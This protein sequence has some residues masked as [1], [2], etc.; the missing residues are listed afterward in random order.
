MATTVNPAA[1][2]IPDEA[3]L[4]DR[5]RV[6]VRRR[7]RPLVVAALFQGMVL[8]VPVEK[9]FMSEIGF[10]ARSIGIMAAAYA[11]VVP[12]LEIP[13]GILADRWSRRGVLMIASLALMASEL[14]GG[15]STSVTTYIVA[16]LLLGVFFAMQSGTVDTIVYDTVVEETGDSTPFERTIGRVRV[17][18]S[19]ALVL[20]ALAGG[21]LAELVPL[22]ATYFITAPLIVLAGEPQLHQIENADT[23][24]RY[25]ELRDRGVVFLSEPE[26]MGYGGIDA[27]FEDGCGNLLNLHQDAPAASNG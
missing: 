24:H 5:P 4:A 8:W 11:A 14:V 7:L 9:L 15:L 25:R 10:D 13:S 3:A 26:A 19:A 18:E 17:V 23:L 2:P 21:A 22:R 27:V 12:F 20:G 16:A 6:R 1:D